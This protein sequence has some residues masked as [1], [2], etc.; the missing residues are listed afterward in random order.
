MVSDVS[1]LGEL[2]RATSASLRFNLRCAEREPSRFLFVAMRGT[3]IQQ[4]R[5]ADAWRVYRPVFRDEDL[6]LMPWYL[7]LPGSFSGRSSSS[8]TMSSM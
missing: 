2:S 8:S 7:T 1:R 3:H 5:E 6:R 4:R